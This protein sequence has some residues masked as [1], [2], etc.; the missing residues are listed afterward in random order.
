MI[1]A[2]VLLASERVV[3]V[4]TATPQQGNFEQLPAA[5]GDLDTWARFVSATDETEVG[6]GLKT[7]GA[8][9]TMLIAFSARLKGSTPSQAPS[10]VFVHASAGVNANAGNVRNKTLKF[11]LTPASASAQRPV[12]TATNGSSAA[13]IDLSS[14]LGADDE[15]PGARVNF[16]TARITAAEF[17]RIAR[18]EQPTATVL[19][20]DVAFRP[21]QLRALRGF[22]NRIFLKVPEP[23]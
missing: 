12:R 3:R 17:L 21:D 11:V 22:A 19:G 13:V 18:S 23:Q 6:I 15:A 1:V 7:A 4:E 2:T 8:K 20:V 5:W 9:T 16:A 14:R 10:D